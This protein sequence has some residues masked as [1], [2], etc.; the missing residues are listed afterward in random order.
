MPQQ[1][2]GLLEQWHELGTWGAE[3]ESLLWESL[4]PHNRGR[5]NGKCIAESV[6]NKLALFQRPL[7]SMDTA[8]R[9]C[10]SDT[11]NTALQVQRCY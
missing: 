6:Q 1:N 10:I 9:M 2:L 7:N 4:N 5:L 11:E 3:A 8:R